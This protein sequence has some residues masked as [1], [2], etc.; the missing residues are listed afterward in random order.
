[1]ETNR[2]NQLEHDSNGHR[3]G[4]AERGETS[5]CSAMIRLPRYLCRSAGGLRRPGLSSGYPQSESDWRG[6]GSRSEAAPS[7]PSTAPTLL[8]GAGDG[9]RIL[10]IEHNAEIR[11]LVRF[12][13]ERQGFN[14][15][16]AGTG[17]E[18]LEM[19]ARCRPWA[20]LLDLGITDVSGLAVIQRLRE[21]SAIPILALASHQGIPG[22]VS[23]L[24]HGANDYLAR[25][26]SLEELGA[27]LRALRRSAPA[28]APET[29]RSGSVSV[30]LASRTV[31]VGDR[32]VNL[33][34]TEYSLLHLFVRHAGRV[35]THAQ[36]L[37]AV[38]GSEMVNKVA[39]LRVYLLALRKK[40]ET[41]TEPGLFVTERSV[42]YRLVVREP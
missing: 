20:V 27:R 21:W 6:P 37:G 12:G 24:D 42:G 3:S 28:P 26:F 9:G 7:L 40:L 17:S 2:E 33:S 4:P 22:A 18:A 39:Y 11:G 35:L 16:E 10:L 41:P 36:I 23:A 14:V 29:F 30:D 5:E 8:G 13:L 31:K 15:L 38:W 25:P 1:M 32:A 34:A 19:A